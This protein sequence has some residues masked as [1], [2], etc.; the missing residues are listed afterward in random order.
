MSASAALVDALFF[1]GQ[2]MLR[3]LTAGESHGESLTTI[4]EGFPS[5]ISIDQEVVNNELARRQKGFGRGQRMQIEQD[6]VEILSGVRGGKTLGSP[7][8]LRIRNRDWENWKE[9]MSVEEV[10]G[11]ARTVTRPRPGHADLA[12][13]IKYGHK[14]LRNVLER[15]SARETAAR[16]AVGAMAKILLDR[17]NVEVLGHVLSIGGSTVSEEELSRPQMGPAV[18]SSP[19]R[20]LDKIVEKQIV[21]RI[22]KAQSHYVHWDRR[23]DADL[24]MAVMSVPAIKGV[25]IGLGFEA[26][27]RPGSQAHDAIS[28][29]RSKGFVRD[30]N[31]AG[32]IE[33]GVSNGEPIVVEAAMKPIPT[34]TDPLPSVHFI[35]K[36]KVSAAVER[37]DVTAVPAACVIGEAVVAFVLANHICVKFGGDSI[38]EMQRNFQ[39][40]LTYVRNL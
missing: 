40:Y 30:T 11:D 4:L 35:S 1:G 29:E 22:E 5:G 10:T 36:R 38:E 31:R 9:I 8:T 32:G 12:G 21:E 6:R 28:F 37:S 34:L 39:G 2:D 13:G 18:E 16:V 3:F 23:L 33:G 24:A 25:Q 15:A 19:V 26:A 27:R 17:F 20:C 7:I 14:D